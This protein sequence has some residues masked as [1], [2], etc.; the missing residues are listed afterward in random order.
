VLYVAQI[1][2]NVGYLL[3]MLSKICRAS[4]PFLMFFVYLNLTFTCVMEVIHISF[5][6]TASKVFLGEYQG[7]HL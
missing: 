4:V 6:E 2:P 7:Y 5:D 1:F 3:K